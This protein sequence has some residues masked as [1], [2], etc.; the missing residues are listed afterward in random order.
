VHI[1]PLMSKHVCI[2]QVAVL[3]TLL[4]A[5][6]RQKTSSVAIVRGKVTLDGKP[7]AS[8]SI[9]TLPAAGR[10]ASAPIQMGEFELST[11][12]KND[13]A[14]MGIHKVAVTATEPPQGTGPEAAAG[15]SLVPPRYGNPD[16]SGLTIEVKA[17]EVNTPTLELTSP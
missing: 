7:L 2:V 10:G 9:V 12:S 4:C 11:F 13:G 17:D 5:G 16:T 8:G 1:M 15:K 3:T 14:V 6:C